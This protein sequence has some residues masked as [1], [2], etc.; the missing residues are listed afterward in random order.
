MCS[1]EQGLSLPCSQSQHSFGACSPC[2]SSLRFSAALVKAVLPSPS[3]VLPAALVCTSHSKDSSKG[4]PC[5]GH[6]VLCGYHQQ[7]VGDTCFSCE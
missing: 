1:T 4:E 3:D 2:S 7:A 5:L 6:P